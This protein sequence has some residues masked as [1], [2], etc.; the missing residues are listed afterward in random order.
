[1]GYK[2]IAA[3]DAVKQFKGRRITVQVAKAAKVKGD[4]GIER[5]GFKTDDVELAPAHVLSAKQWDDGRVT[6]T[7]ID[8]QR[9]EAAAGKAAE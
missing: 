6:I 8:G 7:T 1:M 9:H 4:D 5:A 3:A 2:E